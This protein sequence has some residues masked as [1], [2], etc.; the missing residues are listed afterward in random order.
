MEKNYKYSKCC[1]HCSH[2][3]DKINCNDVNEKYCEKF[4]K[5]VDSFMICDFFESYL[6]EDE[7]KED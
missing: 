6:I 4:D 5:T 7:N 3:W 1:A 2:V